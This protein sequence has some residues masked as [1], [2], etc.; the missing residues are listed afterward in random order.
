MQNVTIAPIRT[1][2]K[3]SSLT[4]KEVAYFE[5]FKNIGK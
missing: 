2:A 4:I 5:Y 3:I 1:N